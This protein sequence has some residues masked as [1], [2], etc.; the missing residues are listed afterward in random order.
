M[1]GKCE[2]IG[3]MTN[4]CAADNQC[5]VHMTYERILLNIEAV[6]VYEILWNSTIN[7]GCGGQE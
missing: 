1:I 2:R 5:H 7:V 3:F 6:L 4:C